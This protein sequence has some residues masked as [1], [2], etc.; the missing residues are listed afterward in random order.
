MKRPSRILS[1]VI[2]AMLVASGM[3][4]YA[5]KASKVKDTLVYSVEDDIVNMNTNAKLNQLEKLFTALMADT[6]GRSIG[7]GKYEMLLAKSVDVSPDGKTYT[8]KLRQGVKFHDGTEMTAEDVKFT[9]ENGLTIPN[10]VGDMKAME[11]FEAKD[12]YTFI[13]HMKGPDALSYNVIM[14]A[15]AIMPKA[16]FEKVGELGYSQ[17]P[18]GTGPFKYVSREK[19]ANV[20]LE[21]FDQYWGKA[22]ALRAITFVVINDLTTASAALEAGQIDMMRLTNAA[23]IGVLQSN[24]KV[25]ITAVPSTNINY[26]LVNPDRKPFDNLKVRQALAYAVD[27]KAMVEVLAAGFGNSQSIVC[28]KSVFGYSDDVTPKYDYNVAKAKALLAEAGIKTP[29]DIGPIVT[30]PSSAPAAQM[31]QYDLSQIG[32]NANI[33]QFDMST[34]FQAMASGEFTLGMWDCGVGPDLGGI[35]WLF[36]SDGVVNYSKLRLPRI[37]E[38]FNLA[39]AE[40]KPAK[41]LAYYKELLSL[42]QSEAK[43]IMLYDNDY[44]YANNIDLVTPVHPNGNFT[45]AD[46][47]WKK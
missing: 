12:R 44:L 9:F 4:A 16:Y 25:K 5:Q 23:T 27:R 1:L 28:P 42:V 15:F 2:V 14:T 35:D 6:L 21:R 26:F 30:W 38:L 24:P 8:V 43:Y 45:L 22:P 32:I 34:A 46:F 17:K 3:A 37:D 40:S 29:I 7:D 19:G 33:Q 13:V 41:R 10:Q 20:K 36:K 39:S 11:S 18:I 31:L 47:S